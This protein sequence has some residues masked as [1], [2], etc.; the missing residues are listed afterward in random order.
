MSMAV[1]IFG[2]GGSTGGGGGDVRLET[3]HN[4]TIET[5]GT[6]VVT[7]QE[8]YDG[9]RKATIKVDVPSA[10]T[11]ADKALAQATTLDGRL[12]N[13]W[14]VLPQ[15]KADPRVS[16]YACIMLAEYWQGY[17][18]IALVGANAFVTCDGA[19]YQANSLTEEF[20]HIWRDYISGYSNRWV[21]YLFT[22]VKTGLKFKDADVIPRNAI[23]DGDFGG[24]IIERLT[25]RCNSFL[26]T[27]GSTINFISINEASAST[28][29]GNIYYGTILDTLASKVVVANVSCENLVC[30]IEKSTTN[31]QVVQNVRASKNIIFPRITQIT[32]DASLIYA[33]AGNIVIDNSLVANQLVTAPSII[34]MNTATTSTLATI[35]KIE[36][37]SLTS[38][39]SFVHS[40]ASVANLAPNLIHIEIGQGYY[41]DLYIRQFGFANCLLTDSNSLV[42]DVVAHPT[43][44]NLDQWLWNFEHLIVD[45]LA[46][47]S[48][49]TAKTITLAAAPYAAITSEIR[50]KMSAKNWNLA[51]A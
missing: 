33:Y 23:I 48:G 34:G 13:L 7:P 17:T 25:N 46:D 21:A 38:T 22:N 40:A 1:G 10:G 5:N 32:K 11:A 18:S 51:S 24:I 20:T 12:Y 30:E 44:S 8:G 6:H 45:K 37:K 26:T 9:M 4:A 15:V 36:L 19:F 31:S 49:Q 2:G 41:S 14:E 27:S 16:G 43:W 50:S 42:E 29:S 3:N 47:L 35:K 28:Q 39:K